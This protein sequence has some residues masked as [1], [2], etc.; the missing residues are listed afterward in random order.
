MCF[1][2]SIYVITSFLPTSTS[3]LI[4]DVVTSHLPSHPYS[5]GAQESIFVPDPYQMLPLLWDAF[6]PIFESLAEP[7]W[8]V[9]N[10]L[11][12]QAVDLDIRERGKLCAPKITTSES[13]I[14][15]IVIVPSTPLS[16]NPLSSF[17]HLPFW[18][19]RW[20]P[21]PP[22]KLHVNWL[23]YASSVGYIPVYWNS[24][25]LHGCHK[26]HLLVC[27]TEPQTCITCSA[28]RQPTTY[29]YVTQQ[30]HSQM[31]PLKM[32]SASFRTKQSDRSAQKW[33]YLNVI[34]E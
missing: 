4:W 20:Q 25:L 16:I 32:C 29:I 18:I 19:L 17:S 24:L 31:L 9:T 28:T 21:Q 26:R 14:N 30:N 27:P 11:A 15:P 12:V 5:L 2:H 13:G 7:S 23:Y 6:V 22:C 33:W 1:S 3:T 10:W 34:D 8:E